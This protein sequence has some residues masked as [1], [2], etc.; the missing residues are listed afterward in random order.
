MNP[1]SN[2]MIAELEALLGGNKVLKGD[3]IGADFAHDELP[4]GKFCAPAL[5]CEAASTEDVAAVLTVCNRETV[6]VTVR[7]A[8]TGLVGGSVPVCGGVVLSLAKMN[9]ILELDSEK[10]RR[11]FSRAFFLRRSRLRQPPRDCIIRP[12]PARKPRPSAEMRRRTPVDP[13]R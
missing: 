9:A 5:V 7:G 2:E 8:G 11:A 3:A 1:I 6:P 10:K 13:A 4:G 12:I